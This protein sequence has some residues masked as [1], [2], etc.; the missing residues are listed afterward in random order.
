MSTATRRR[1]PLAAPLKLIVGTRSTPKVFI[2]HYKEAKSDDTTL[3]KQIKNLYLT[4]PDVFS[5]P[6]EFVELY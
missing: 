5:Q 1:A 6:I 4:R 2:A 3:A